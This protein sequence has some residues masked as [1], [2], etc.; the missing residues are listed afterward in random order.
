[1]GHKGVSK[2]KPKKSQPSSSGNAGGFSN[3]RPG[4]SP[5]VQSLVKDSGTTFNKGGTNPATN[6][7]N[8][9]NRQGK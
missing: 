8:K 5:T 3:T 2:R 6:G 7:S 4:E 9:K 1:M